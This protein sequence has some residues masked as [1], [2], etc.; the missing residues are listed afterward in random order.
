VKLY[1]W[2][3]SRRM[4]ALERLARKSG[5]GDP[6]RRSRRDRRDFNSQV[7]GKRS[8]LPTLLVDSPE[9]IAY[10]RAATGATPGSQSEPSRPPA[11]WVSL[12]RRTAR[13]LPRFR[14]LEPPTFRRSRRTVRTPNRVGDFFSP[15]PT[16]RGTPRDLASP[17]RAAGFGT[18]CKEWTCKNPR[19]AR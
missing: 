9:I 3:D 18:L 15:A 6:E 13:T 4:L 12:A 19:R 8:D 16:C 1:A 2:R 17:G 14:T 7:M 11:D 10:N 5:S